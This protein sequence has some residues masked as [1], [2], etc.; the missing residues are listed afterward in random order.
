VAERLLEQALEGTFELAGREGPRQVRLRGQADR[1][2]LLVDGGFRIVDY[3]TGRAANWRRSIQL[4][5]YAVCASHWL[6]ASRGGSWDVKEAAYLVFAG[7]ENVRE[8]ASGG[9]GAPQAFAEEQQRFLDAVDGMAR[10]E[11]PPRPEDSG[12]CRYC[13]FALLCRREYVVDE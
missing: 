11:F 2:D 12:L 13:R 4:P 10:G 8:L 9:R 3:K 7:R 1:I 5:I 6:A